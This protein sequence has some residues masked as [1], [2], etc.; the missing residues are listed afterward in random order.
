[1]SWIVGEHKQTKYGWSEII[2]VVNGMATLKHPDGTTTEFPC[3]AAE[4]ART[5]SVNGRKRVSYAKTPKAPKAPKVPKEKKAKKEVDPVEALNK[6]I[7]EAT[8]RKAALE[9]MDN[10]G[11]TPNSLKN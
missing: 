9:A 7:A 2:S 3:P 1:M 4:T 6:L 5:I 11:H 8:A 10:K